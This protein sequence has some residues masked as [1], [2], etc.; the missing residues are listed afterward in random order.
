MRAEHFGP[1]SRIWLRTRG[2]EGSGGNYQLMS[3][4][5]EERAIA[6]WSSFRRR[7]ARLRDLWKV[8]GETA[9]DALRGG[10]DGPYPGAPRGAAEEVP[11]ESAAWSEIE[12]RAEHSGSDLRIGLP[13]SR[14]V[15]RLL[16]AHGGGTED[17]GSALLA[18]FGGCLLDPLSDGFDPRAALLRRQVLPTG[19]WRESHERLSRACGGKHLSCLHLGHG[20]R[21]ARRLATDPF[22]WVG[23]GFLAALAIW[24]A[25]SFARPSTSM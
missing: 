24:R 3:Q 2:K 23:R 4:F 11:P 7:Q 12:V 19:Q 13:T 20:S 10:R 6:F 15:E 18:I 1:G 16:R 14:P 22:V 21:G 25:D 8:G 9:T 17:R 5:I